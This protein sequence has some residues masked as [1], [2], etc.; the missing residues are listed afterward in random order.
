MS[1]S[2]VQGVLEAEDA[3]KIRHLVFKK[4]LARMIRIKHAFFVR[5]LIPLMWE[6]VLL[7]GGDCYVLQVSIRQPTLFDDSDSCP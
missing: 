7:V 5:A 1:G 4:F 6:V 2:V 3:V